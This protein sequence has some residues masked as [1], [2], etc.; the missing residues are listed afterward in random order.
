MLAT[1]EGAAIYVSVG[2]GF[3][4]QTKRLVEEIQVLECVDMADLRGAAQWHAGSAGPRATP[5][6]LYDLPRPGSGVGQTHGSER[7]S[8][9]DHV[10]SDGGEEAP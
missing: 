10:H 6:A 2:N 9:L 8:D 7:R 1:G 3:P 4:P 5:P